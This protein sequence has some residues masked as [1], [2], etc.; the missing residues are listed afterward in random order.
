MKTKTI[1]CT[2]IITALLL[3]GCT[4]N[5]DQ[6]MDQTSSS[7][8][9][10]S[11]SAMQSAATDTQQATTQNSS[12]DTQDHSQE[13]VMLSQEEAKA[14]ALAHAELVAEEVTFIKSELEKEDA[15]QTYDVEFYTNEQKKYD[16]EIDAYTGE[17]LAYD[18]D[19]EWTAQASG[20]VEGE[21]ITADR[22]KQ[23]ALEKVKGATLRDILE[24]ETEY[25]NGKVKYEGKIL[26]EQTEYD[27][28]IDGDYGTILKW[29]VEP[30]RTKTS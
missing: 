17:I 16:Y 20:A 3:T 25:D 22:A 18:H 11:D 23:I 1:F 7:D 26:Y 12:P 27:F 14:I 9:A 30:A 28:E 5:R 29:E 6:E 8:S 13:S 4:R 21:E 19:T 15:R 24:F 2:F 10:V